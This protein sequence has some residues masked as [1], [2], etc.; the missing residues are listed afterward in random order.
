MLAQNCDQGRKA[1]GLAVRSSGPNSSVGLSIDAFSL[2]SAVPTGGKIVTFRFRICAAVVGVTTSDSVTSN[3]LRPFVKDL[4]TG[5][6]W[7][8]IGPDYGFNKPRTIDTFTSTAVLRRVSN[9]VVGSTITVLDIPVSTSARNTDG[10]VK[11][12]EVGLIDIN[13]FNP[14]RTEVYRMDVSVVVTDPTSIYFGTSKP[15]F[16]VTM[17]TEVTVPAQ[18]SVWIP[19]TTEMI[20][21]TGIGRV[22]VFGGTGLADLG[23]DDTFSGRPVVGLDSN[24]IKDTFSPGQSFAIRID[25][26]SIAPARNTKLLVV[27]ETTRTSGSYREATY[28]VIDVVGLAAPGSGGGGCTPNLTLPPP[29]PAFLSVERVQNNGTKLTFDHVC[30]ATSYSI[31]G[32]TSAGVQ[33][34]ETLMNTT[35]T[36]NLT[37]FD[38]RAYAQ[39][40]RNPQVVITYRV[41]ARNGSGSSIGISE[42]C[43]G[44]PIQGGPC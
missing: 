33:F 37:F 36:A 11:K 38:N 26:I 18:S 5:E 34:T 1:A 6:T 4:E 41:V 7:S 28:R 29:N 39:T 10:T 44:T 13:S 19:V 3:Q 31:T 35:S 20:S 43:N 17:P 21:G 16:R 9:G 12:F 27:F 2:A 15:N 8:A 14:V 23:S 30:S 42:T 25:K 40:N 24:V 22:T 32:T